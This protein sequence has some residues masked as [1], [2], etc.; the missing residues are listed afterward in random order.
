MAS[1]LLNLA[2]PHRVKTY[3]LR[4]R[5]AANKQAAVFEAFDHRL[6]VP[7]ALK[8]PLEDH[9]PRL[10][11]EV[12][13]FLREPRLMARINHPH[14]VR[15]FA[16]EE[17]PPWHFTVYELAGGDL[18]DFLRRFE[19][20]GRLS[21]PL[22]LRLFYEV[23]LGL[24]IVHAQEIFHRD[25]KP[26]NVLWFPG[27]QGHDLPIFRIGDF[28]ISRRLAGAERAET[29]IGTIPYMAPETFRGEG[30]LRSD[31]YSMGALLY[32]LLT[33][34]TPYGAN[35]LLAHRQF[36][37]RED[38]VPPSEHRPDVPPALDVLVQAA[39]ARDPERRIPTARALRD[40]VAALLGEK[41]LEL[42]AALAAGPRP[43]DPRAGEET[44][45][46]TG[47]PS[48]QPAF[49]VRVWT[50][51]AADRS[52]R[53]PHCVPRAESNAGRIGDTFRIVCVCERDAHLTLVNVGPT[54]NVT[55]LFPNA[56][57]TENRVRGGEVVRVPGDG[58]GFE[59]VLSAPAG[60][61]TLIA[62]ATADPV[63]IAPEDVPT[64]DQPFVTAPA[65]TRARD[66]VVRRI[67]TRLADLPP[68]R[69]AEARCYLDVLE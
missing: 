7:V 25:L 42:A 40:R 10:P 1:D 47:V 65:G 52:T 33:G 19:P 64:R 57:A 16:V 30:T 4:R 21:V 12:E 31:I 56:Y 29:E 69:W 3:E 60:R 61:E 59:Y 15:V 62:I 43:Q 66:V 36:L 26:Q 28:G 37:A 46:I 44:L 49:H 11:E 14:V 39:L 68:D 67:R 27:P 22:S 5:L 32:E 20:P 6:E 2:L 34:R 45:S 17:P 23:C 58:H 35:N 51:R 50:E 8:I 13:D 38:P 24:E 54:G 63:R 55:I 41:E 9:Q 53:D 18:K 48:A